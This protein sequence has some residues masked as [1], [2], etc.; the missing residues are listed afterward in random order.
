M[1]VAGVHGEVTC[2]GIVVVTYGVK[3]AYECRWCASQWG[4][5]GRIA[6][7]IGQQCMTN[8]KN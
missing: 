4:I 1:N 5:R 3:K 6:D 8:D 7:E 2:Y